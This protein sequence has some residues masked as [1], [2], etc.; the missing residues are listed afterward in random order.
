MSRFVITLIRMSLSGAVLFG[1]F[2]AVVVIPTT[3]ADEVDKFPPYQPYA[4]PYVTAAVLALLSV[5][6]ALLAVMALLSMVERDA[7]F[8]P[9]AFVWVN[10]IIGCFTFA[11]ALDAAVTVHLFVWGIP[12]PDDGMEVLGAVFGT[13]ACAAL[14]V[15][16]VLLMLVMR[17]LL[18]KAIELRSEMAEVI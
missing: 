18:H 14:G 17:E 12:T 7:I 15:T 8:T 1:L 3:A 10:V 11:T 4:L 13:G 16:F 5:L 6:A 9:R 2:F